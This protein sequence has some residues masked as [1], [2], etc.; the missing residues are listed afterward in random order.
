MD[1]YVNVLVFY[2]E[3]SFL[4]KLLILISIFVYVNWIKINV[5]N[6]FLWILIKNKLFCIF[7]L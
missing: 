5:W 4:I 7:R 6:L 2:F 1:V 3:C